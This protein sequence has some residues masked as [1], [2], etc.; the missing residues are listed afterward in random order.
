MQ[1]LPTFIKRK[2]ESAVKLYSS[3]TYQLSFYRLTKPMSLCLHTICPQ[4]LSQTCLS[5]LLFCLFIINLT[6]SVQCI[7]SSSSSGS[8]PPRQVLMYD[9]AT[10]LAVG[11]LAFHNCLPSSNPALSVLVFLQFTF[12]PSITVLSSSS[13][14][15]SNP[16][17][18][19][20]SYCVY[21]V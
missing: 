16:F 21:T 11:P 7:C 9:V 13:K 17:P 1:N 10:H 15:V 8:M 2:F 14:H 3:A 5:T 20:L 19:S 12:P 4:C 6:C 18:S